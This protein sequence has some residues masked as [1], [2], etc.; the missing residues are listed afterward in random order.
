MSSF[1]C[2]RYNLRVNYL[3]YF[4][5]LFLISS[6]GGGGGGGAP[7]V[8]FAITLAPNS[9]SIN[10]DSTYSGSL[11]ATANEVVTLQYTLVNSTS[12]G[13]LAFGSDA[14][15]NYEPNNNYK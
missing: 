3:R 11:T 13:S 1:F 2:L 9:I 12:N 10:E 5:V 8:P 4:L 7:P 15:I 6:C 14:S